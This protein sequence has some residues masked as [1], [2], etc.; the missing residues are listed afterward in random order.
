MTSFLSDQS[1]RLL[2]AHRNP[3]TVFGEVVKTTP[4]TFKLAN[5]NAPF[6]HVIFPLDQSECSIFTST[7]QN[8]PFSH[9]PIRTQIQKWS[10]GAHTTT[11]FITCVTLQLV[12]MACVAFRLVSVASVAFEIVLLASI[13]VRSSFLGV[14]CLQAC[15]P[16]VCRS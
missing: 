1:Q 10:Q 13:A 7:N 5:H 3:L 4:Q 9:Q 6:S 12:F 2:S 15:F 16:G 8:A 11:V 14:C